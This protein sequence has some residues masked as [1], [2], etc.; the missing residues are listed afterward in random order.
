VKLFRKLDKVIPTNRFD[1]ETWLAD[2]SRNIAVSGLGVT[3]LAGQITE[4]EKRCIAMHTCIETPSRQ[5]EREKGDET[6]C[7][8]HLAPEHQAEFELPIIKNHRAA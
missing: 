6:L 1:L 2:P 8:S 7:D 4:L 3:L 5:R